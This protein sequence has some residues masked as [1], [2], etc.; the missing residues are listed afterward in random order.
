MTSEEDQFITGIVED[1]SDKECDYFVQIQ[2]D[3]G[4][5]TSSKIKLKNES[6]Q[7]L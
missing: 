3:S 4:V 7:I 6:F 2:S 5:Y 1:L